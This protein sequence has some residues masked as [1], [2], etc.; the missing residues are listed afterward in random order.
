MFKKILVILILGMFLVS[1][2]RKGND[3]VEYNS[4]DTLDT[5]PS[6]WYVYFNFINIK[7][8]GFAI[9]SDNDNSSVSFVGEPDNEKIQV[10]WDGNPT[11]LN[12]GYYAGQPVTSYGFY[13]YFDTPKDLSMSGYSQL[14]F[15]LEGNI[16]NDVR[17]DIYVDGSMYPVGKIESLK[18]DDSVQ[19]H[20]IPL[21]STLGSSVLE[22]VKFNF[23]SLNIEG[24]SCNGVEFFIDNI[25]F[26]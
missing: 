7:D 2:S 4:I 8:G 17:L 15:D 24:G 11:I 12:G 10:I 14:T 3:D 6:E 22:I 19:I 18:I 21:T 5:F 13:F 20:S 26:S 9:I 23:V 16:G 1:C 25:K